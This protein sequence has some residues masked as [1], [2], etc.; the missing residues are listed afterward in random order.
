M[1]KLENRGYAL[2]VVLYLIRTTSNQ[3]KKKILC[4]CMQRSQRHLVKLHVNHSHARSASKKFPCDMWIFCFLPP[5]ILRDLNISP[6]FHC[7]GE[8]PF[9]SLGLFVFVQWLT[10]LNLS[11]YRNSELRQQLSNSTSTEVLL[12]CLIG[13]VCVC[14][15]MCVC[16]GLI[17]YTA[18]PPSLIF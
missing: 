14:V 13:S 3:S 17:S 11:C 5:M 9:F 16:G 18:A 10:N 15:V 2:C 8:L 6:F 7:V 4:G 12:P 1:T